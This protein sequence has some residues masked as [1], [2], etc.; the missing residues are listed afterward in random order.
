MAKQDLKAFVAKSDDNI[1]KAIAVLTTSERGRVAL[2]D[3]N[4]F[5]NPNTMG[6]DSQGS[7]AVH[8]L[9]REFCINQRRGFIK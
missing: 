6:L 3:L 4:R 1:K 7:E 2:V 8:V 9:V 5:L